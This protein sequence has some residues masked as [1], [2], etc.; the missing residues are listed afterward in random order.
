MSQFNVQI[1]AA[2]VGCL[3]GVGTYMTSL[4]TANNEQ[5]TE[6][7]PMYSVTPLGVSGSSQAANTVDR[8]VELVFAGDIMLAD[9]PGEMIARGGDPF[10]E[11][12]PILQA[13]DASIGNLECVVSTRGVAI[14][15]PFTFRAN[16]RV[17]PVLARHF[18]FVSLANN[19]TGDF[20]HEAFVEQLDLLAQQQIACFGGGRDCAAARQPLLLNLHGLKIAL[21]GYNDF[22]PRSFEAGAS[23]P[24]VAWSVDEQVVADL[25]AA[26]TL[27]KADLVIPYMHWGD[28]SDP[29]NE[30]QKSLARLMI[31]HGADLV[32]GGHPHVTQGAEYY[33]GKLIVYSLGNFV[34]DGFDEGPGREGWLLRLKLNRQGLVAWD[35]VVAQMDDH[36]I[37]HLRSDIA[38]PAGSTGSTQ[39]ENR[40]ALVDSPLNP[41][42]QVI[43]NSIGMKLA[44]IPSGDFIMGN[45]ESA[46]DMSRAFPAY[47]A[48]RI[49]K[50]D[51]ER[52]HQVRITKPFY[53]GIHEVSVG[54]FKQFVD[55]TCQGSESE[56]DG[57]GAWGYNAQIAYFEGRRPEYS[58]RNP[59]FPQTASHPVVNVTWND[60]NAFCQWLSRKEGHNY[61]LP[62]EAEW[63]YACRAGSA[64]RYH[65]GDDP[66]SLASVAALF[67]AQTARL[68][69]QFKKYATAA[70]DG[71]EFTAP[72]GSF[73]PNPFGLY[74]MHGNVW[75]WCSD[76]YEEDYY[77][78]SPTDD[79]TGPTTGVVRVRRG[80]SWHSWPLYLRSSFRNYNTPDT[81]YVLVGFRVVMSAD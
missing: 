68:F 47:D 36:G 52:P 41:K 2:F 74:D 14:E 65:N 22:Q 57:T 80:G 19:H 4:S 26:R 51:D 43:T 60:A 37:P 27:H 29:A 67:D 13:A 17:L 15:K 21:L 3:A 49:D 64:T 78:H 6:S 56:R 12:A 50:L 72:T 54:Q 45:R 53:L 11:F 77:A 70:S 8:D 76:W 55:E 63:E 5:K 39:I 59:G 61:R 81:R 69:P 34:F 23:W 44:R 35:T 1:F 66:E 58:W 30:R 40:R 46:A 10:A 7:R 24:G 20:G 25:H 75:E 71:H 16:P 28:E 31:D 33:K 9:L 42:L 38:S 73:P 18:R 79:P 62:T 48:A 32:I